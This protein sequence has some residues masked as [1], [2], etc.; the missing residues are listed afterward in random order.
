MLSLPF[1][2]DSIEG[3]AVD[4]ENEKGVIV[5][6]HSIYNLAVY[7]LEKATQLAKVPFLF[8]YYLFQTDK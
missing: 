7:D 2:V 8:I 6:A 1:S 5:V 3:V 4:G